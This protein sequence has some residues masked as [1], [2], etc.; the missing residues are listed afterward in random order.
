MTE[1]VLATTPSDSEAVGT[2]MTY[3]IPVVAPS[4][5][6]LVQTEKTCKSALASYSSALPAGTLKPTKVYVVAVGGVY[7]VWAPIGGSTV[8]WT[9]HVILDSKFAL[10]TKF[11]G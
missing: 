7:V 11:A 6:H 9:P 8:E 1:L 10:L 3:K 2:R 5:I 4:Q